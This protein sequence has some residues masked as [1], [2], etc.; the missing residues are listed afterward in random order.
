M[1][2]GNLYDAIGVAPSEEQRVEE[3]WEQIFSLQEKEWVDFSSLENGSGGEIWITS[4]GAKV[5]KG[6]V[7]KPAVMPKPAPLP[8]V[9]TSYETGLRWLLQYLGPGH[10]RYSEALVYEQR[11]SENIAR[12]RLHGDTETRRAERS[13]IISR[14][15]ELALLAVGKSFSELRDPTTPSPPQP[16]NVP[17][18]APSPLQA[19]DVP[20]TVAIP[21][22][23]SWV[24]SPLDDPEAHDNEKP[25]H[26]VELR[27]YRIGRYPITNAQYARF[28]ADNP[29]HPVPHADEERAR[30]YNWDSHA[31]TYPEG[32]ADHPVVLVS[33]HDAETYCRWLSQ[34]TGQHYRLPTEE[35]WEK[36]A[37]G[38]SPETRR[39]PWGNEWN[40]GYCNVQ[41]LGRNC[42]TSVHEFEQTNKSPFGVVDMA[43]N[44]WEW[45]ASWYE[46]YPG[47]PHEGLHND[48]FHRVVRGGSWHS[49]PQSVRISCRG[50]Y[51]PD[52]QRPYLGFRIALDAGSES[53]DTTS[54]QKTIEQLEQADTSAQMLHSASQR[55]ESVEAIDRVALRQNLITH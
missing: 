9:Y 31:R 15:D 10:S 16:L 4:K 22:G 32:K 18:T 26:E 11:L 43:G 36:A 46:P 48:Q 5:A 2:F 52:A 34:V 14:L 19:L 28:L 25:C 27:G 13:E 17:V 8:D 40:P 12:S 44:V 51:E 54:R 55:E 47:S 38:G 29:D 42:T 50:R 53:V 45:T 49:D 7:K 6:I 24:G 35:E 41:E 37:R 1:T 20:A 30:P 23:P 33:W 21:A 3:V 39:Y